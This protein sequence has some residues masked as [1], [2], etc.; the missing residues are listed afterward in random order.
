MEQNGYLTPAEFERSMKALERHISAGFERTDSRLESIEASLI[1]LA[2]RVAVLESAKPAE[3]KR[4]MAGAGA[5]AT[6]VALVLESL[7]MAFLR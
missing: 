7:R 2:E 5:I 6:A 1:P 3:T 4:T